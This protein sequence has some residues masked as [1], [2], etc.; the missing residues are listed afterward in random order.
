M[1]DIGPTA[2]AYQRWSTPDQGKGDSQ[3][4]QDDMVKAYWEEKG[5]TL[6]DTHVDAGVSAFRGANAATGKLKV[7]M[8]EI[9]SGRLKVDYILIEAY[10]RMS[11]E[12]ALDAIQ[13]LT[14]IVTLGPTLVT[15]NNKQEY[16]K[17]SLRE[18]P[19]QLV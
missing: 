4:R 3:K 5:L 7:L 16:S 18:N 1:G 8:S 10:D 15:L 2:I 17:K 19:M 6:I 12:T 9:A 11:R 14:A 13:L